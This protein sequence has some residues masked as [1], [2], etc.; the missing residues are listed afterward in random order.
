M[1][2]LLVLLLFIST[3]WVQGSSLKLPPA[4]REML[5]RRLAGWKF[6]EVS[7]E[8]EQFFKTELKG[9]SP[10]LIQG[11][12][13]GNGR[14]DY[15][16]L[17]QRRSQYYLVVFLRRGATYKLYVISN[18]NGEYLALAKKGTRDYNYDTQKEITYE[19]DAILTCIFEKAGSSYVYKNG[20]FVSFV[21]SD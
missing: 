1:K 13:D 4:A 2:V 7:P 16:A 3:S 6:S 5:N 12:F 8:V 9:A 21:S 15:A 17:V 11:D 19:N 14:R 10:V 18:P 20:R